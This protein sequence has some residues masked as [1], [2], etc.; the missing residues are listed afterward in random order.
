[1]EKVYKCCICHRVLENSKPIRLVK[2]LYGIGNYKQ[3]APVDKF[4]FC[5]DCYE[6]FSK[7]IRKHEQVPK[8]TKK[9]HS[10]YNN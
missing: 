3:Y 6:T 1:M 9:S 2:Q 8:L 7:W 10:W 5:F 4:D